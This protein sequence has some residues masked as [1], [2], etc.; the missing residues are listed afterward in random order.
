HKLVA[1]SLR[2]LAEN[3]W[4]PVIDDANAKPDSVSR[5]LLCSGK[6]YIDLI[7]NALRE[8]SPHVAIARI[9]QLYPFPSDLLKPILDRYANLKEIVWVQEEPENM[10][11]W[12]F[13]RSFLTDLIAGRCP[14]RYVGRARSSSPA[15]GSSSWHA[16]NQDT[17]IKEAYDS[18]V[19]AHKEGFIL[20]K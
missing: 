10:G 15:E 13:V 5:L 16:A 4:Q 14:L 3:S 6:I 18:E 20:E 11:A 2:E 1:S 8:S 12:E 7:S 19:L 17:L 9:E